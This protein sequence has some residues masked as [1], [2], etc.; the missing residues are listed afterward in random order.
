MA[1]NPFIGKSIA[2]QQP[3][4]G[5]FSPDFGKGPQ[6]LWPG[7]EDSVAGDIRRGVGMRAEVT[8]LLSLPSGMPSSARWLWERGAPQLPSNPRLASVLLG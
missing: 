4:Q 5:Q 7:A 6:N 3:G 1:V 8:F 2:S